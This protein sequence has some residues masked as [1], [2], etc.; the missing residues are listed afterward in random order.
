MPLFDLRHVLS[1]EGSQPLDFAFSPDGRTLAV[2]WEDGVQRIDTAGGQDLGDRLRCPGGQCLAFSPD[3]RR[4]LAGSRTGALH[5]WDTATGAEVSPLP[6]TPGPDVR[7]LGFA[8]DGRT[9]F[10]AHGDGTIR[11]W[12]A[13]KGRPRGG[14]IPGADLQRRVRFS[15]DG[16]S[17]FSI[18]GDRLRRWDAETG[19]PAEAPPLDRVMNYA[20]GPDG[21]TVLTLRDGAAWRHDLRTGRAIGEPLGFPGLF[22]SI[23]GRPQEFVAAP[24][25][26]HVLVQ[27]N[28]GAYALWDLTTRRRLGEVTRLD[29]GRC[30]FSP[31]GRYLLTVGEPGA[32]RLW[33]VNADAWR[34]AA[35]AAGPRGEAVVRDAVF[36][37]DG[38][39]AA[40]LLGD[41]TVQLWDTGAGRPVGRPLRHP[42]PV[43]RLAADPS[44]RC[45]AVT[46]YRQGGENPGP[47]NLVQVWDL[48]SQQSLW[49][50]SQPRPATSVAFSPDGRTLAAGG[51]SGAVGLFDA[52]TGRRAGPDLPVESIIHSLLFSPD[53]KVLAAGCWNTNRRPGGIQL[54]DV[55]TGRPLSAFLPHAVPVPPSGL[56]VNAEVLD[57]FSPDG[58]VLLTHGGASVAAG[59][60]GI[61]TFQINGW[62]V[63][64]GR[65]AFAPLKA[66]WLVRLS[67]DGRTLVTGDWDERTLHLRDAATGEV[68]PHGVLN[69][70]ARQT[71][72]A[73][74]PDSRLLATGYGN[75]AQLWDVDTGLPVG[76]P[77]GQASPLVG[78]G[79][80]DG[81]RTLVTV[82]AAGW[83]RRWPIPAPLPG[84][85]ESLADRV[86]LRTQARVEANGVVVFLDGAALTDCW[87]QVRAGQ[88]APPPAAPA[89]WHEAAAAAAEESGDS[90]SARWHLQ[91]LA[92]AQAEGWQTH[93]RLARLHQSAGD[94][95]AAVRA[96]EQALRLGPRAD[97]LA[98]AAQGAAAAEAAGAW[99]EA[100]WYLSRLTAGEP[101]EWRHFAD[102]AAVLR[103]LGRTAE[104]EEDLKRAVARGG[105]VLFLEQVAE[106][107]AEQG[108]WPEVAALFQRAVAQGSRSWHHAGIAALQASDAAAYRRVCAAVL[109][110]GAPTDP[111]EANNRAAVCALGPD[112]VGDYSEHLSL[113]ERALTALEEGLR[114]SPG[115]E[116][117]PEIAAVRHAYRNTR[118]ALLYRAGRLPEAVAVLT[119]A[120]Q[121]DGDRPL[122]HDAF[123]LALAC[124]GLG[125]KQEAQTWMERARTLRKARPNGDRWA[126]WELQLLQEEATRAL[127]P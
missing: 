65:P 115:L 24:D 97:V 100:L 44:G 121:A 60:R 45:L 67:P 11:L 63:A 116:A 103:R 28:L 68:R 118:G 55:G 12:D 9:L 30:R 50:T 124:R 88:E 108:R 36:T 87:Q 82:S 78:A 95:E 49:A 80:T 74:S 90:V 76:P 69:L 84:D 15:P 101:G 81:G 34:A 43:Q 21:T 17:L 83:V 127:R 99:E 77:V 102:R 105:D 8:P 46:C 23:P 89:A 122:P 79:F 66:S 16:R 48:A 38:R 107:W 13:A 53:G 93:A 5:A 26:G 96:Y 73:F 10:T 27:D 2:L 47:E 22:P 125:R 58:R 72:L 92:E 104:R 3:G 35:A 6:A 14:A 51:Y 86:R 111:D 31:D 109:A 39:T 117:R 1:A 114:R 41:R 7:Q 112:G 40:L 119:Q 59:P 91:R 120:I 61:A 126:D 19:R 52:A 64:S 42:L 62:E 94:G 71:T 18:V 4:L 75:R 25:G 110:A 57:A 56:A 70:P 106:E 33:E 29:G 32:L 20:L 113:V 123:L 98:W 37:P 54:W 85:L